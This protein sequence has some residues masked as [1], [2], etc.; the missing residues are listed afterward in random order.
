LVAVAGL[1]WMIYRPDRVLPFDMLD[2]SE[3]LPTLQSRNSFGSRLAG[4]IEYYAR[5]GRLNLLQYFFVDLRWTLFGFWSPGW[6]W[7]RMVVMLVIVTL[8]Y[9]LLRRL[10][11]TAFGASAGSAV[12]LVAPPATAGWIRLTMGEPMATV[13]LLLTCQL[14]LQDPRWWQR[15]SRVALLAVLLALILL[16]K[17]VLAATFLLPLTLCMMLSD[18]G[19]LREPQFRPGARRFA[20]VAAITSA[21][22]LLPVLLVM[23]SAASTAYAAQFGGRLRSPGEIIASWLSSYVPFMVSG[24]PA[25]IA[26][27]AL[28]AGLALV[29]IGWG[30]RL[31][32][33]PNA[34]LQRSLLAI[35]L[36]MPLA[37]ILVYAPWPVF[38][39]FYSVP[40]MVGASIGIGLALSSLERASRAAAVGGYALWT[41]LLLV[42]AMDAAAQARL[43][44]ARQLAI[45]ATI[46]RLSSVAGSSDTVFVATDVRPTQTWQ[47]AG[48][49]IER[50][51]VALGRR[52]PTLVNA[53]CGQTRQRVD[54]AAAGGVF[55][56]SL[57]PKPESSQ[58]IVERFNR[59][60]V[61][62][63][64]PSIDSFRVDVIV[65]RTDA[66]RSGDR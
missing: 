5:Q 33:E 29:A 64:R 48:P 18:D 17:E 55:F 21:V 51:G 27:V 62:S 52:M 37:G 1:T 15:W 66:Q 23:R 50:Y 6:Q 40:F 41:L 46:E 19:T 2:F 20:F 26:G 45:M 42:G 34:R 53:P 8:T 44:A 22:M 36:A 30:I 49:T 59:F 31:R 43:S 65:P 10:G 11:C 56:S 24:A 38:A 28:V 47:G 3:F 32:R 16:A 14:V 13:C 60:S 35:S 58:P 9:R 57:C 7:S 12:F 25:R 4:L 39:A 54:A 63:I 61:R